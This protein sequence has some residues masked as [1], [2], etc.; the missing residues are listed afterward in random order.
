MAFIMAN[1][2]D[3]GLG[4]SVA[5][6]ASLE[7][8]GEMKPQPNRVPVGLE[9]SPLG[10]AILSVTLWEVELRGGFGKP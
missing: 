3:G 6:S 7:Q 5:D 4:T 1:I 9:Q 2:Q 8:N 10:G